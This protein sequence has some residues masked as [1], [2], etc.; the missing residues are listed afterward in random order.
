MTVEIAAHEMGTGTATTQTMVTADRLGLAMECVTVN[1][2]DSHFPG[3]VLAGGSQ[4]TASIGASVTAAHEKLITELLKLAGKDSPLHGLD[5]DEV[6]GRDGQLCKI[7]EPER[8][9][10]YVSLMARTGREEITAEASAPPPLEF[11]HWSMH[12][13]GAM[14]REVRVNSVSGETRVGRSRFF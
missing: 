2:G 8:R 4:Q 5:A 6:I 7:D 14:F 3:V 1:Y 13:Q 9:E 10:S 11:T 12:S